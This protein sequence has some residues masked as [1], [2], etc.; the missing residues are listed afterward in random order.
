MEF[1]IFKNS[2]D[3]VKLL[4]NVETA[5]F[6]EKKEEKQNN[7]SCDS[8]NDEKITRYNCGLSE[9]APSCNDCVATIVIKHFTQ[10]VKGFG[11]VCVQPSGKEIRTLFPRIPE[12]G[13]L[14]RPELK[15]FYTNF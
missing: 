14:S 10:T 7:K 9:T 6:G 12:S 3:N 11:T 8:I 4:R 5:F 13:G 1:L 15:L 2:K